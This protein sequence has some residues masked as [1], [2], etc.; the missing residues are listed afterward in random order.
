[1]FLF[2]NIHDRNYQQLYPDLG[3]VRFDISDRQLANAKNRDW[4]LITANSIACVVNSSRRMS[5]LYLIEEVKKTDV[6]DEHGHQHVVI[7]PVF[8]KI[9]GDPDMTAM[10]NKHAAVHEYLPGNKFSIGFNVA[11]LG[12]QLDEILVRYDKRTISVRELKALADTLGD[13]VKLTGGQ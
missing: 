12:T 3:P 2:N 13:T 1:M 6:V 10:L 8:A 5:T 9:P 4:S 11:Y 7:G